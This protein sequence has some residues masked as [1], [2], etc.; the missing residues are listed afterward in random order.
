MAK[1]SAAK[2]AAFHR[3]ARIAAVNE[4]KV[5]PPRPAAQ[6]LAAIEQSNEQSTGHK[7]DFSAERESSEAN[8]TEQ[9]VLWRRR[10]D[11]NRRI[12][13]LQTSALTTWLRRHFRRDRVL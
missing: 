9:D 8:A 4:P 12:E 1:H 5:L 13:V 2:L 3:T 7:D 11:S 6:A 10:P